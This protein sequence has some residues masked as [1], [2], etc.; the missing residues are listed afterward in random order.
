MVNKMCAQFTANNSIEFNNK[1]RL[2]VSDVDE[3]IADVYQSAEP[4]MTA[5]LEKLLAE[6]RVLFMISGHSAKGIEERIVKNISP[7]SRSRLLIGHCSGAEV[8]GY[9][10]LGRMLDEPFYSLY[11][12][13]LNDEQ[14]LKLRE[15][16]SQIVEEFKFT[17]Y[18]S[19]PVSDFISKTGGDPL[20][21]MLEDRGPQI[22]FEIINGYDLAS[23]QVHSLPFDL[24][25]GEHGFDIRDAIKTK[26]ERRLQDEGIPVTARKAGVFALDLAVEGVSKTTAVRYVVENEELLAKLGLDVD[27]EQ[28]PDEIEVWGDKFSQKRGGTDRHISE[29]LPKGVRSVD[30]REED[31]S[32]FLEGYNIVVWNGKAHLHNGLLEYLKSRKYV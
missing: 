19:G 2:I 10:E 20:A 17:V 15:I 5:E 27:I 30:F 9:D 12:D 18:P 22:T 24:P 16:V 13:K 14:K 4:E 25:E 23:D 3:T 29:G 11:E 26:I 21:V 31:P 7:Q 6:G 1:V 32:E 8:Y 28:K